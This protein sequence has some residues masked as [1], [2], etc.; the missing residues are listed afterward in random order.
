MALVL[1]RLLVS[2]TRRYPELTF[3][4]P[5]VALRVSNAACPNL[6]RASEIR[7]AAITRRSLR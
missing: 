3:V 2:N 6:W 4:L 7:A 1:I 5:T